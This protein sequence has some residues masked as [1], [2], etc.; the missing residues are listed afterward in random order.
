MKTVTLFNLAR[1]TMSLV[2]F[3][4]ATWLAAGAT[5]A[6]A[7]PA[8]DETE[9]LGLGFKVLAA[10][11]ST[12]EDWVRRLPQGKVKAVQRNGSKYFIFRDPTRTQIYVGGPKE[13]AAYQE[14][15][16]ESQPGTQEAAQ[17]G[18]AARAKQNTVM[19]DATARDLTNP[20]LGVGW[21]DLIW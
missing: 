13:Y 20:F 3:A 4:A 17:K 5:A 11:N 14:L 6:A 9:L 19:Q 2:A 16:P 12:Q 21:S 1:R 7:S 18:A 8:V 10:T 15:H